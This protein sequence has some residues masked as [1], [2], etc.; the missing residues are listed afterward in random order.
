[1]QPDETLRDTTAKVYHETD[2]TKVHFFLWTGPVAALTLLE[3][4]GQPPIPL[5]RP[6]QTRPYSYRGLRPRSPVILA[7]GLGEEH[8]NFALRNFLL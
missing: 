1:M 5:N 7:C 3:F 4:T 8:Q 6:I 2:L